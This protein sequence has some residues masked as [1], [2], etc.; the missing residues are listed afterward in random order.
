[1]V[2]GTAV[3]GILD[4]GQWS[5]CFGLSYRDFYLH[6]MTTNQRVVRPGG[7]E[8]RVLGGAGGIPTNRNKITQRWLAETDADWLWFIDSDM[9]FAP[10]TLDRLIESADPVNR[11]VMGGL[12]FAG[13]R[14]KPVPGQLGY[15][16]R[17][18][19]QPTVYEWV[20]LSDQVGFRPIVDYGRDQVIE[21]AATGAACIVIHRSVAEKVAAQYGPA[22]YDPITHPTG[23]NGQPRTFSEDLSFCVRAAAVGSPIHVDTAVKTVHEK[24]HVFLSEDAFDRQ[25]AFEALAPK[26]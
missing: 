13:L 17:F 8:L 22:W 9:G 11:P 5:A 25:L 4:P 6:D 12:C 16:E 19:I 18:L 26:E 3:V 2:P 24:G 7:G 15:E 1:M 21:V 10:D 23:L 20:E 14:R